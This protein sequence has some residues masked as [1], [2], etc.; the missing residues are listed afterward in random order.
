[1]S[2]FDEIV[3]LELAYTI[4]ETTIG[5]PVEF[6]YEVLMVLEAVTLDQNCVPPMAFIPDKICKNIKF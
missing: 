1:M 4:T 3:V 6:V 5:F 2:T